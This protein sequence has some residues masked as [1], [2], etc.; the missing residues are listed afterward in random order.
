LSTAPTPAGGGWFSIAAMLAGARAVLPLSIGAFPFGL[1]YGVTVVESSM[2][3]FVGLLASFIVLAGAAQLA[4]VDLIDQGAPWFIVVGTALVINARFMMYSG[5]MAPSFSQYPKR[6]R[7]GLAF[8]MTDQAT[9]TS[10]LYNE[11]ERKPR[12]RLAYYF[13]AGA[14]FALAW[15]IGTVI[16]VVIGASIPAEFQVGFAAPLMF[17]ALAV[18]SIKDRAALIAAAVG[19]SVTLIARDAPMNTGL[20]VGAAAGIAFGM[21]AK[22]RGNGSD[23]TDD[24]GASATGGEVPHGQ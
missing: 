13:G 20:L 1:A 17:V 9:V 19:F 2:N 16:G 12:L 4:M 18:P 7:V 10:L 8:F 14:S 6:W 15:W 21:L 24:A 23:G 3:D 22:T 11:K 5:A